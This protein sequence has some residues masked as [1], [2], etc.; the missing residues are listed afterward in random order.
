M[1]VSGP[2]GT[3]AVR[4]AGG[5]T[6]G[7]GW[8]PWITGPREGQPPTERPVRVNPLTRTDH[9]PPGTRRVAGHP[10]G[11]GHAAPAA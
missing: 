8:V 7:A 1:T 3:S 6:P 5:G 10:V 9:V 4:A 2:G 11:D